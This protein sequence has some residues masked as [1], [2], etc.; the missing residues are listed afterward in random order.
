[1]TVAASLILVVTLILLGGV[2]LL[3]HIGSKAVGKA[4]INVWLKDQITPSQNSELIDA[5]RAMP[6]VANVV[7]A[8]KDQAYEKYQ[9]MFAGSPSLVAHVSPLALPAS[10]RI[11]PKNPKTAGAV[12]RQIRSRRG[13]TGVHATVDATLRLLRT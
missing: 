4:E 7:Y 11:T 3:R 2:A 6:E 1:M 8:S 9:E 10:L 12:R 5:I 13:V